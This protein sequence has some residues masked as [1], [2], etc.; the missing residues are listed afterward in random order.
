MQMLSKIVDSNVQT[1]TPKI[2][3]VCICPSHKPS[4][5]G[6]TDPSAIFTGDGETAMNSSKSTATLTQERA[7]VSLVAPIPKDANF[8]RE[9]VDA[10]NLDAKKSKKNTV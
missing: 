3:E 2:A 5:L 9:V 4:E 8:A 7:G 10:V 6:I 1:A